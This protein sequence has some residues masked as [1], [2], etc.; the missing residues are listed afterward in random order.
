[1]NGSP[2]GNFIVVEVKLFAVVKQLVGAT[3]TSI[4]L[5]SPANVAELRAALVAA[6]PQIA[7]IVGGLQF[8]VG[9]EYADDS[10]PIPPHAEV[11]CIPPVS[12]G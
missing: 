1:M 9:G 8:A 6:H 3:S 11:A 4:R 5:A 2:A 12:G 10:T 7:L